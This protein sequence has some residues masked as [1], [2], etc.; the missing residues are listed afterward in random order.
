MNKIKN[1]PFNILIKIINIMFFLGF[2]ASQDM[3]I[4]NTII[5]IKISKIFTPGSFKNIRLFIQLWFIVF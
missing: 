4:N 1:I 5:E 2:K 3:K